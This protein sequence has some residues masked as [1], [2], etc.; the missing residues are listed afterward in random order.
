MTAY[1]PDWQVH[2]NSQI[3]GFGTPTFA[4]ADI[5]AI[6]CVTVTPNGHLTGDIRISLSGSV[7]LCAPSPPSTPSSH[8]PPRLTRIHSNTMSPS[9]TPFPDRT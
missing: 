6:L 1:P 7:L 2:H 8:S 4:D 9:R 5:V 3:I